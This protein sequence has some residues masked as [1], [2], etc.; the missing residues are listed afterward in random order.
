MANSYH[1]AAVYRMNTLW[2]LRSLFQQIGAARL[3]FRMLKS[4]SDFACYFPKPLKFIPN[5]HSSLMYALRLYPFMG[6]IL[7]CTQKPY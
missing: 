5:L 3:D 1:F 4:P 6:T 2:S 7:F